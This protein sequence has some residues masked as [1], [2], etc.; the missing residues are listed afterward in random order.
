MILV[1]TIGDNSITEIYLTVH[2]KWVKIILY[3]WYLNEVG[4]KSCNNISHAEYSFALHASNHYLVSTY[5]FPLKGTSQP[6]GKRKSLFYLKTAQIVLF[7]SSRQLYIY[8]SLQG[9][10]KNFHPIF[11]SDIV[12]STIHHMFLFEDLL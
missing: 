12:L 6:H 8:M 2:L 10:P 9:L 7:L 5:I 1:L 11:F 3:K 4:E